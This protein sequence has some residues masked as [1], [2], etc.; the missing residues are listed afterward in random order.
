MIKPAFRWQAEAAKATKVA[1]A[2]GVRRTT[3]KNMCS[4]QSIT[5]AICEAGYMPPQSRRDLL[6]ASPSVLEATFMSMCHYCFRCRRPACPACWDTMHGVCGACVQEAHLPFRA[7]VSPLE[8][9][10]FPP[11]DSSHSPLPPNTHLE[12]SSTG[13]AIAPLLVCIR[14]GRFQQRTVALETYESTNTVER[15][16]AIPTKKYQPES[17]I[18]Q[19]ATAVRKTQPSKVLHSDVIKEQQATSVRKP[20]PSKVVRSDAI[21]E[22]QATAVRKPQPA[23]VVRSE[24]KAVP[25]QGVEAVLVRTAMNIFTTLE[26]VLNVILVSVLLG[27]LVL[28][29]LGEFS[30]GANVRIMQLFHV[31]IRNEMAYILYVIQQLHV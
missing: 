8:G 22:Q 11:S 7:T 3:S 1:G 18:E 16:P 15:A 10:L 5:C 25:V 24:E 4:M 26:R 20:Q 9:I 28:I 6:E 2:A 13:T 29:L 14:P 30:G 17:V 31:D 12:Q 23:V 21:K 19:R 27:V